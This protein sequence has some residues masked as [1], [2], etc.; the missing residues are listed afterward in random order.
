MNIITLLNIYKNNQ[1]FLPHQ[2]Y[3]PITL[4]II[5]DPVIC[6]DGIT[7]DKSSIL[8][9]KEKINP[10]TKLPIDDTIMIENI[11][12]KQL[13]DEFTEYKQKEIKQS[14]II[15]PHQFIC[16]ITLEIMIDPVICQDGF[17]YEKSAILSL[18]KKISPMTRSPIDTNNIIENIAIKQLIE[19]FNKYKQQELKEIKLREQEI[20]LK[21]QEIKLREQE[22]KLRE[23]EIKIREQEIKIKQL[24]EYN[25]NQSELNQNSSELIESGLNQNSS[26]LI[27]SE[28]NLHC[29]YIGKKILIHGLLSKFGQKI[30][31]KLAIIIFKHKYL[32]SIKL[33]ENIEKVKTILLKIENMQFIE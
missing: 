5:N 32:F 29:N 11:F 17:T 8:S 12:I 10:I 14:N 18:K 7:Y 16:P 4:K 13:I 1:L 24:I 33:I 21:E 19:E 6:K 20:K 23:Q 3:C 27:K 2:F 31:N 30:N 22:I 25:L 28:L 15:Y 26:E 9:L